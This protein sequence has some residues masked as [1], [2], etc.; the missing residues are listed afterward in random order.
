M[1]AKI[2]E[3]LAFGALFGT[4]TALTW[5]PLL[6]IFSTDLSWWQVPLAD[7]GVFAAV[8]LLFFLLGLLTAWI[9]VPTE[10]DVARRAVAA[11]RAWR[12]KGRP[13]EHRLLAAKEWAALA[14]KAHARVRRHSVVLIVSFPLALIA[15]WWISFLLWHSLGEALHI[16]A[17]NPVRLV[18]GIVFALVA[19]AGLLVVI[20]DTVGQPA[21]AVVGSVIGKERAEAK[22]TGIV[23]LLGIIPPANVRIR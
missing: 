9:E 8:T 4:F 23:R 13:N 6:L 22:A 20:L 19:G 15:G 17:S 1:W 5:G 3:N 7:L 21:A 12:A 16:E 11:R 14:E 18:A 2:E 10:A